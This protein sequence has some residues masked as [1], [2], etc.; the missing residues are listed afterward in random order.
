MREIARG[1][2]ALFVLIP[3]DI[4][5][6][7]TWCTHINWHVAIIFFCEKKEKKRC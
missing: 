2:T 4:T 5:M 1:K 7:V 3:V 6:H